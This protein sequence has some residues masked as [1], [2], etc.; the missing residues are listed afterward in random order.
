[1]GAKPSNKQEGAIYI[2]TLLARICEP[3]IE[4]DRISLVETNRALFC[5]PIPEKIKIDLSFHLCYTEEARILVWVLRLNFG[6]M[7][8]RED[9]K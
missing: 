6:L 9:I 4:I 8:S 1:M 2:G 7:H 3:D 5:S